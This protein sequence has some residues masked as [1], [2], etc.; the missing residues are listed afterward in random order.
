MA[1]DATSLAP[2]LAELVV[3]HRP[4]SFGLALVDGGDLSGMIDD[5]LRTFDHLRR[6]VN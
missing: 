1:G 4:T 6:I 3:R 2:R 5:A